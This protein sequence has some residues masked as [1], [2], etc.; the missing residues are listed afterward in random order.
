MSLCISGPNSQINIDLSLKIK[1]GLLNGIGCFKC[2][3][4]SKGTVLKNN[5][6]LY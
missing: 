3:L 6:N 2:V 1:T 4:K 5:V